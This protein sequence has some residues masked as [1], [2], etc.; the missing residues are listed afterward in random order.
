[1]VFGN[2]EK[3]KETNEEQN[4]LKDGTSLKQNEF[5]ATT[6]KTKN[7]KTKKKKSYL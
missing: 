4:L 2:P 6:S 7:K 5:N 1:M 3:T